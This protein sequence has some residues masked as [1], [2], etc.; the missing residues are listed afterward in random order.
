MIPRLQV[1]IEANLAASELGPIAT[2][3]VVPEGAVR[4]T[5]FLGTSSDR[6]GSPEGTQSYYATAS[7]ALGSLPVTACGTLNYSEWDEGWNVP[8]GAYVEVAP[9]L[10]LQPMY[11]GERTHALVHYARERWS[12]SLIWAWLES[13]GVA[14]SFGW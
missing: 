10:V 4:P 1:G 9:G 3:F 8:F 13:A 6:I 12:A 11:D 7:K 5:V 2:L 14:V